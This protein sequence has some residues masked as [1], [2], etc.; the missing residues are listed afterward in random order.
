MD[1][2]LKQVAGYLYRK[3]K[4]GLNEFCLVFPSRRAGVF[5]N[6]YLNELVEKP[7]IGPETTT[8]NQ[9]FSDFSE[10]EQADPVSLI[11][12]LHE[13]YN[14]VTGFNETVDEF[15]FWGEILLSDFDDIDKYMLDTDDLFTNIS[16]LKELEQ[17]FDYLT[18]EQR[19]AIENFWGALG[20]TGHSLNKEKFLALWEKLPTIYHRFTEHLHQQKIGYNGLIC[21]ELAENPEVFFTR[22]TGIREFVFIGFNALNNCEETIFKSLRNA[23]KALF[24]W[25]FDDD[26]A[27]D[28]ASEAGY[29]L[30]TNLLQ[31]PAPSDFI[32]GGPGPEKK[33]NIRIVSVPGKMA[34]AQ[35]VNTPDITGCFKT[36]EHFDNTALVLADESLLLP[37]ISA[38]GN[39]FGKMNVTMGFPLTAT[40]VY[41][42]L[43]QLIGLQRNIRRNADGIPQFY[44]KPVISLL[45]H[46]F[47]S[48]AETTEFIRSIHLHNKVY[49][50]QEEL[51]INKLTAKIFM[52]AEGWEATFDYLLEVIRTLAGAFQTKEDGSA[53][54]EAE[55]LYQSFLS[56]SRLKDSIAAL[57]VPEFPQKILFRLIDQNL[58]H[59]S[60][61]F[62]GEPLTGL[63]VMGLLE[64]R[65]LDFKNIIVFSANE[66]NLPNIGNSHSFIPYHLRKGHG[67]PTYE[68]RDAM[69]AYYFY[70]LIQRAE[71]VV[72]VYNSVTDGTN[73]AEMSRYLFQL[74]YE[75][76]TKPE[77]MSLTFDFKGNGQQAIQIEATSRHQEL[78]FHKYSEKM[79][80]PSAINTYLDCKLKFYFK[81]IVGLKEQDELKEEID[82]VL[83][84]NL[85]HYAVELVYKPFGNTEIT[86]GNIDALLLNKHKIEE[87]VFLSFAE[88]YYNLKPEQAKKLKL[89]GH[90]LLVAGHI[91]YYL[92]QLLKKD[93]QFTPFRILELEGGHTGVFGV[94]AGARTREIR[95]GGIIDRIDQ[96]SNGVRIVDYKTGRNLDLN[97]NQWE[98]L[99]DR[100]M[101]NRRKEIFQTLLYAGIYQ[102]EHPG[103]TVIPAIYRLDDLF[104][105]EFNP[106]ITRQNRE[107]TYRDVEAD[108]REILQNLLNEIFSHTN[109][110][111]QTGDVRK[112]G[113]CPFNKI[114]NRG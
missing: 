10:L 46:Q 106:H 97:F 20:K 104:G 22:N 33:Q 110:Y 92:T 73:S 71:N 88:K 100:E 52:V 18:E 41:G 19:K 78:L 29:F 43:S 37:V 62:E 96:T 56:V 63:Q 84:G 70:N 6:A 95:L 72:F 105:E 57:K 44:F 49:L 14:E 68:E 40:P 89:N 32:A 81:Y 90:N 28:T 87:A 99:T 47:V 7:L 85:F 80:T 53:R 36:G 17:K 102:A 64:T 112:C 98:Q 11:L 59:I 76:A 39:K 113:Y 86:A 74:Q 69:Y 111:S 101:L 58:R 34:Q 51:T 65:C 42:F 3:H 1:P 25:D 67:I 114:C 83:F 15:F 55:Y 61:P 108:F 54:L 35:V 12:K 50:S 93:R 91:Q 45:S 75:S 16:D 31:F 103:A 2:F 60:V 30:R 77:F 9:L 24:F 38:T 27:Q 21:R 4:N 94:Q 82:P 8:I 66:G 48:S 13:I 23:Q 107:F 79:L 26:F 5:F 109:L